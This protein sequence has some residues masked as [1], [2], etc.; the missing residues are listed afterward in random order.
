MEEDFGALF[1]YNYRR[2]ILINLRNRKK[3]LREEFLLKERN[4]ELK[5]ERKKREAEVLYNFFKNKEEQD[6]I[7]ITPEEDILIDDKLQLAEVLKEGLIAL[8]YELRLIKNIEIRKNIKDDIDTNMLIKEIE[9]DINNIS[10]IKEDEVI[11]KE[12]VGIIKDILYDNSI[13]RIIEDK[14]RNIGLSLDKTTLTNWIEFDKEVFVYDEFIKGTIN[15]LQ[16]IDNKLDNNLIKEEDSKEIIN[17]SFN[18]SYKVLMTLA[19]ATKKE[20]PI[21]RIVSINMGLSLMRDI[22]NPNI[23]VKE[24]NSYAIKG[25]TK[26]IE[27][28]YMD[29]SYCRLFILDS[30]RK[31]YEISKELKKRRN[32]KEYNTLLKHV[33]SIIKELDNQELELVNMVKQKDNYKVY[34]KE[35]EDNG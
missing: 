22:V 7:L 1:G 27:R 15:E 6:I 17:D 14:K 32:S 24:Y 34:I 9:E 4:K 3:R 26:E 10:Y 28:C 8:L 35:M 29:P 18:K 19:I 33:N 20:N 21:D 31:T 30:K 23:K 13:E 11:T 5:K 25:Y 16:E 2:R 12:E